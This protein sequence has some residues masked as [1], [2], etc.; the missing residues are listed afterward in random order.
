[1]QN[2]ID[3]GLLYTYAD[4]NG[5]LCPAGWRLPTAAEWL[6]LNSYNANDLKNPDYWLQPNSNSN[7]TYFD[8]RG[9]GY[10][11]STLQ[12]FMDLYGYTGWWSSDASPSSNAAGLGTIMRYYCDYIEIVTKEADAISVRCLLGD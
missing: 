2:A 8:A 5:V 9:A 3:F 10:Y 1:V 11:N 7:S 12:R 4:L 6:L